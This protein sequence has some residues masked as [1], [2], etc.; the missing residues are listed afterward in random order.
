[1]AKPQP[2]K[3][4]QIRRMFGLAKQFAEV[5]GRETKD[6]I[7]EVIFCQIE[8]NPPISDLTFDEANAVIKSLG[9]DPFR[10]YGNSK[11]NENYKK[12]QA[13]IKTI[14][15]DAHLRK[16]E[17]LAGKL[18]WDAD[19]LRGF[20]QRQIKRDTPTTTE[21]GNKVLEGLKAMVNRKNNVV[22]FPKAKG[23][24]PH[25]SKGASSSSQPSFRRVA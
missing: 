1:M 4:F 14:E 17:D 11:R 21:E 13:G 6:Y 16:I 18:D 20:C 3:N 25:G 23:R 10:A 7:E 8:R 22:S 15:T 5:S 19:R 9:G 2:K 24:S 12:Q